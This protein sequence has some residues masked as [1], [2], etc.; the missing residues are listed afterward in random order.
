MTS[1]AMPTW[2][3][4]GV[5]AAVAAAIFAA[6]CVLMG[7]P[8]H[9]LVAVLMVAALWGLSLLLRRHRTLTR[10]DGLDCIIVGVLVA[11]AL[12]VRLAS[13]IYLDF[14]QGNVDLSGT[15]PAP[16]GVHRSAT[17][18]VLGV[19][20]WGLGYP[21]NKAGCTQVPVGPHQTEV[22]RC[23]FVF[24]EVYFPVDALKDLKGIDYFDPEPPLSK[25]IMAT[26]ISWLGFNAWGWRIMSAIF[27]SLVIGLLYFLGRRLWPKRR[28]FPLLAA[29]FF[30]LD[31]L[32]LVSSRTGVIDIFA[33][34]FV[35]LG[36]WLFTLHWHARTR[37]E[38]LWTLYL[39][40]AVAGLGVATKADMIPPLMLMGLLLALRWVRPHL[41][42]RGLGGGNSHWLLPPVPDDPGEAGRRTMVASLRW[43]WHYLG[44]LLLIAFI[45]Y[46]SFFRYWTV[47]HSIYVNFADTSGPS[48]TCR[49]LTTEAD[50][51]HLPVAMPV[52]KDHIG[53][54]T[55]WLPTSFNLEQ[56]VV[57]VEMNSIAGLSYQATLKA[58]HPFASPY[59]TWP[60]D[61]HPVLFYAEYTGNGVTTASGET[62]SNY[63]W[64]DDMGNPAIFWMGLLALAACLY[65]TFR[66]RDR[67][68]LFILLGFLFD[69]LILWSWPSRILFF[70]EI[71]EALPFT[72]LALAYCCTKLAHAHSAFQ[73]GRIRLGP[74]S[75]RPLAGAV[76]LAVV[77]S[78]IYFY[79]LWTGQPI[80]STNFFQ[81]V[82]LPGWY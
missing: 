60:L 28:S 27:G 45:F 61:G 10:I 64:I 24:D 36:L 48:A 8:V 39:T 81:H 65:W 67:V 82:W 47:P 49:S 44:A 14:L 3:R 26:G 78:F 25:L 34:F 29:L 5:G 19:G 51:C 62:V 13:P 22:K 59:Y 18:D 46:L 72:C 76:V 42:L 55:L 50:V 79:P 6:L 40:A 54:I 1:T 71:L 20:A 17:H 43:A 9:P 30:S 21:F 69:W 68:A 23:G 56:S 73:L 31:G 33:V 66:R 63:T 53:P 52:Q 75:L 11:A 38:W 2:Q 74:Y 70:Y 58:T 16:A 80:S 4:E 7:W 57:D 35:V 12:V 77:L 32:E 37:S 41:R 15:V